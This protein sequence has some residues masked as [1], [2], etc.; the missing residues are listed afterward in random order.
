MGASQ[1]KQKA[2]SKNMMMREPPVR[3]KGWE[4]SKSEKR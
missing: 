3:Q 1:A 4:Q 2:K